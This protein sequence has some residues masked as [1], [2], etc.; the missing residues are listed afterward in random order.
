M[1][2]FTTIKNKTFLIIFSTVMISLQM[3]KSETGK[4]LFIAGHGVCSKTNQCTGKDADYHS[5]LSILAQRISASDVSVD[6]IMALVI[7]ASVRSA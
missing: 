5:I 1:L 3:A 2:Q 6:F 4:P 7:S